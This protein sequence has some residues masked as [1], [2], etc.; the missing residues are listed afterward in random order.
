MDR[1]DIRISEQLVEIRVSLCH[2]KR[3]TNRIQLLS[4]A[5]AD[6]VHVRVRMALV[7]GDKLGSKTET[8]DSDIYLSRAHR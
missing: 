8:D 7:N 2:P 3:I 5:L 6:R 4:G 1:I